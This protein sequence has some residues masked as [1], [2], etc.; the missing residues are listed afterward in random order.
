[1]LN[2]LITRHK[3][4]DVVPGGIYWNRRGWDL[5]LMG[6]EGG[7]L[8]TADGDDNQFYRLPVL[9]VMLLSPV[10]GLAFVLFLI[11]A[12]PAM[13]IYSVP[14]AAIAAVHRRGGITGIFRHGGRHGRTA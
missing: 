9:L 1:M 13:L 14:K 5:S 4:G 12:V 6:E 3:A 10:L 2:R 11:V 8:T 7:R